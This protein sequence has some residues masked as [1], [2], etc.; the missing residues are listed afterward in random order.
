MNDEKVRGKIQD[1]SKRIHNFEEV[2]LGYTK[3]EALKEANRCLPWAASMTI[4]TKPTVLG[5]TVA[6]RLT[7]RIHQ[8]SHSYR[9]ATH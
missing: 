1:A 4:Y 5:S 2:E 7:L 9:R 6:S 3:E 8:R